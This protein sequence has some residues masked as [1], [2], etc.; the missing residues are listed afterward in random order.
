MATTKKAEEAKVSEPNLPDVA[1]ES[2][3]ASAGHG[4][5]EQKARVVESTG[6]PDQPSVS[7]PAQAYADEG[8]KQGYVKVQH[9]EREKPL[10]VAPGHEQTVYL[11]AVDK[12]F[13]GEQV[14]ETPNEHY[15]VAGV[16]SGKP[17]PENPEGRTGAEQRG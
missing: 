10:G 1:K 4:T 8:A 7:A 14:D 12:G 11:A 6:G 16:T 5:P 9:D 13:I 15:T 3:S 17:T 2:L